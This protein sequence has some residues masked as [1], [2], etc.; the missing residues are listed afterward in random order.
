MNR[1]RHK[2]SERR[3]FIR[4]AK[5]H[6][7]LKPEKWNITITELNSIIEAQYEHCGFNNLHVFET[8]SW[9]TS[10]RAAGGFV[11]DNTVQ[12]WSYWN[13]LLRKIYHNTRVK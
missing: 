9:S 7:A 12:T 11:W 6:G 8:D 4:L 10:R 1:G 13:T 5:Y 3:R 2:N